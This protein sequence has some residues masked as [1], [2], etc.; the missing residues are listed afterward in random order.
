MAQIVLL[1]KLYRACETQAFIN[2]YYI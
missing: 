2:R 1:N